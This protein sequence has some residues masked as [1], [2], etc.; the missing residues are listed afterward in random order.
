NSAAGVGDTGTLTLDDTTVMPYFRVSHPS[1]QMSGF[2]GLWY[3]NVEELNIKLG[4]ATTNV[5]DIDATG[6][7]MQSVSILGTAGNESFN[8]GQSSSNPL[9]AIHGLV[10]LD[11]GPAGNDTLS[12]AESDFQA[13][14][15][16]SGDC[17]TA[18]T[19]TGQ[20]M[21]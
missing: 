21:D 17:L 5:V 15:S 13:G 11:G 4:L 10:S 18:T 14:V 9:S 3:A 7:G 2:G 19:Y 6:A 8:V 20:G 12:I 16:F 1:V